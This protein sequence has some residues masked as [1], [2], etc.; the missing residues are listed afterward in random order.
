[1]QANRNDKRPYLRNNDDVSNHES[2]MRGIKEHAEFERDADVYF[3]SSAVR[4]RGV[5]F[6]DH[7]R[8]VVLLVLCV[9]VCVALFQFI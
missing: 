5:I 1:M 9:I 4:E 8:R 7:N 6:A 3:Q 2:R